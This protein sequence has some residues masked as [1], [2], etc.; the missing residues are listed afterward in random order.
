M[1]RLYQGSGSLEISLGDELSKAEWPELRLSAARLLRARKKSMAADIL[2]EYDFELRVGTNFFADDFLVL[3][4]SASL[5]QYVALGE[6]ATDKPFADACAAIASTFAELGRY[7]RFI[8]VDLNTRAN[9]PPVSS[10][11]LA[12]T[13]DIVER[14]LIEV[15][16]SIS[17][18]EG[19]NGVDRAH[20]AFHGYLKSI[21]KKA[22]ISFDDEASITDLFKRLQKQHP[23]L[24]AEGARPDDVAKIGRAMASVL[25][26]LGPVRN[27]ASLAHANEALLEGPEAMLVINSIRTL[28]HYLN[29]KVSQV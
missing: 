17:Q 4:F 8:A 25:D 26:A 14:A 22:G 11:S 27:R 23:G 2:E 20:T 9:S 21:C 18:T 28:L 19:V 1:L 29:G 5:D 13:S 24:Q 3:Y 16:R 10:P 15:E 12:I 7:V 6:R